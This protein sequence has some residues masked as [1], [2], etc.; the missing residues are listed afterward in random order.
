MDW[1]LNASSP[2]EKILVMV[3]AIALFSAVM[4]AVLFLSDRLPKW[5]PAIGFLLPTVLMLTFGLLWPAIKTIYDSFLDAASRESVGFD[6]YTEVLTEP[7]FQV[8]LVNTLVWTI[9]VPLFST[10]F[11]LLYAVLVDRT[12]F[13]K[14]AKTLIFLPMAISMVGASIIWKFMYEYRPANVGQTGLINQFLV[15]LG[16]EPYQ[17]LLNPPWNTGFLIVI[18]I[19]IQTGFAMTILSASIK[20]VPD[21]INEAASID[22][23]TGLNTFFF[24]TVPSIRPALIV[25]ITTIAM[26][27]LKVFDIVRTA[28]GGNFQTSVIANEFYSQKFSQNNN[29][30]SAALAVILFVLVIPI[31][32]Y[33]VRQMRISETER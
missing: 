2:A 17:F 27:T 11:G 7:N 15:W 32:V 33:N 14:F 1:L 8:I 5:L 30:I 21:E 22:G 25:V 24:V 10:V 12:R 6:N 9:S 26:A 19:W 4:A 23:A 31:V 18:M 20:A 29:G 3:F 28:T 13:E 16:L